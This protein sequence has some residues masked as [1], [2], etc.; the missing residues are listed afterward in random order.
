[1]DNIEN[2]N[3]FKSLSWQWILVSYCFLVLY[4]LFPTSVLL[5]PRTLKLGDLLNMDPIFHGKEFIPMA[6]WIGVGIAVVSAIVAYRSQQ[7]KILEPAIGATLYCL[8]IILLLHPPAD[9]PP[10][11]FRVGFFAAMCIVSFVVAFAS[12]GFTALLRLR[13]GMDISP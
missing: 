11:F 9:A 1:M 4:H 5:S 6:I 10:Y 13:R 2:R 7:A 12:A 3:L 8:T